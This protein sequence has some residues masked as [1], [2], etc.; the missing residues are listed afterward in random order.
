MKKA[1]ALILTALM[2]V[3]FTACGETDGT[4]APEASKPFNATDL[5]LYQYDKDNMDVDFNDADESYTVEALK[6]LG[7]VTTITEN[8]LSFVKVDGDGYVSYYISKTDYKN[9]LTEVDV[10]LDN[11]DQYFELA[12]EDVWSDEGIE[13]R[14]YYRL[15]D[16]YLFAMVDYDHLYDNT[17][18]AVCRPIEY[19][20]T[21]DVANHLFDWGIYDTRYDE[22]EVWIDFMENE[23]DVYKNVIVSTYP[24]NYIEDNGDGTGTGMA[25]EDVKL[26]NVSIKFYYLKTK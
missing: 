25:H 20:S 22:T 11:F 23:D 4:A 21:I 3:S 8:G 13:F 2:A 9:R 6:A 16:E 7:D 19:I 14:K 10:T 18:D 17:A 26:T 24:N 12:G 15:K 5:M 1:I